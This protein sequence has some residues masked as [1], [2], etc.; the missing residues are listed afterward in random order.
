MILDVVFNHTARTGPDGPALCFRSIDNTAY[1]RTVPGNPRCLHRYHRLRL[2]YW[3]SEMHA[4]EFR[5][6][7]APTLPRNA[8]FLASDRD[9]SIAV[10]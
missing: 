4:D 7:L 6:D 9:A 8:P 3:I 1:Y 5:F 10:A 2:R